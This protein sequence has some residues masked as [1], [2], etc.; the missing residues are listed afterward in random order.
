LFAKNF[1]EEVGINDFIPK[2]VLGKGAF[3]TVLLVEK[4]KTKDW[5]A[6]K[7]I[8]KDDIIKKDQVEHTRT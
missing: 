2:V 3:G 7:S 8:S 6:M 4:K 1:E 5:Y